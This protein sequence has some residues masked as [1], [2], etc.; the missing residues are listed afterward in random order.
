M[1]SSVLRTLA[2]G[3]LLLARAEFGVFAD[4]FDGSPCAYAHP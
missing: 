2:A 1:K 4:G 3:A